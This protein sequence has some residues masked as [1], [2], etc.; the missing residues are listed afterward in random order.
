MNNIP[1]K[2][3]YRNILPLTFDDSLTYYEQMLNLYTVV[4]NCYK[5]VEDIK[6]DVEDIVGKIVDEKTTTI[7][8][9]CN[10][11]TDIKVAD[12]ENDLLQL[13][14]KLD[15]LNNAIVN[16][17]VKITGE[18][19][20]KIERLQNNINAVSESVLILSGIVKDILESQN[21]TYKAIYSKL[22]GAINE[23]MSELSLDVYCWNPVD[24]NY[25]TFE[26]AINDVYD[27]SRYGSYTA[28]EYSERNLSAEEY[29]K[30]KFSA[31]K[32][33]TNV[34]HFWF[35]DKFLKMF[36]GFT[37]KLCRAYEPIQS[38]TD[39]VKPYPLTSENYDKKKITAKNY[40]DYDITAYNYD[41]NGK[42]E[43]EGLKHYKRID[44]VR[45]IPMVQNIDLENRVTTLENDL[46]PTVDG[47]VANRVDDLENITTALTTSY[48][49]LSK[50]VDTHTTSIVQLDNDL[51]DVDRNITELQ[52]DMAEND[53]QIKGA[54]EDIVS[55][56][57]D[58]TNAKEDIEGMKE[59]N[60]RL[61]EQ[62]QTLTTKSSDIETSIA[63]I[64]NTL[65]D[66]TTDIA[67]LSTNYQNIDNRVKAVEDDIPGIQNDITALENKDMEI[68][69]DIV[70]LQTDIGN[71]RKDYTNKF[72]TVNNE[73]TAIDN[74]VN[75]V[76]TKVGDLTKA[77][78][79][80]SN[81]SNV[82]EC[83]NYLHNSI[84]ALT[85]TVESTDSKI[86]VM[87]DLTT[88]DKSSIVKAINELNAKITT[89][90]TKNNSL[91]QEIATI[92]TA[93]LKCIEGGN[94]KLN[95]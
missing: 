85:N 39:W 35:I 7:I 46:D 10:D 41:F 13:S 14:K 42:Y 93:N 47:S 67:S 63:D 59:V 9:R 18:T 43:T 78:I 61:T 56:Q 36:S 54:K 37:G 70:D 65:S 23:Y 45:D 86:G 84:D 88:D 73:I 71:V 1:F 91:K 5:D 52:S 55:L 68:D 74:S 40:D 19:D 50:V 4:N 87:V 83:I 15:N 22:V 64:N 34:K 51:A 16:Q 89:L 94:I 29:D 25:T 3:Q 27:Y 26:K 95:V 11:Y 33:A 57:A 21:E 92:K 8:Q 62:V 17:Y 49:S 77:D 2:P 32:Y 75:A 38:L 30:E 60:K 6:K 66:H 82:V 58:M 79:P 20:K 53:R 76:D 90:T 72:E 44:S 69:K 31:K 81:R 12:V 24:K 28:K 48:N 80:K